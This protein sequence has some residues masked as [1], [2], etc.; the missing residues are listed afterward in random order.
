MTPA[1]LSTL[2]SHALIA[3]TIELDNHFE[4][5]VPSFTTAFGSS[6]PPV[7]SRMAPETAYAADWVSSGPTQRFRIEPNPL[8]SVSM[9]SPARR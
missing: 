9:T 4:A 3:Y 6:A 7:V 2:L 1:P 8:I 5:R